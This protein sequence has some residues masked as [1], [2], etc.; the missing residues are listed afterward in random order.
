MDISSVFLIGALGAAVGAYTCWWLVG[1]Y[2]TN[3]PS[4]REKELWKRIA[5]LQ[6]LLKVPPLFWHVWARYTDELAQS[7][8]DK[9]SRGKHA[10]TNTSGD[11][12]TGET[13]RSDEE[14]S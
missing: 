4:A 13:S 2:Y 14:W 7:A 1:S 12:A 6:A 3:E 11:N 9:K 8:A 10:D 5:E